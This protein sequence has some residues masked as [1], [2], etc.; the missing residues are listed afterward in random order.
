[1][2]YIHFVGE[3]IHNAL[4]KHQQRRN[5]FINKRQQKA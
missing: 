3:A 2:S 1:M 5:L 4:Q